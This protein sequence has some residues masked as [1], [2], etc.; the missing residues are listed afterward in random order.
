MK[1]QSTNQTQPFEETKT[2]PQLHIASINN[3]ISYQ[4]YVSSVCGNSVYQLPM[5]SSGHYC[6][7]LN[8][9][10]ALVLVTVSV[11][12]YLLG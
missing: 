9:W 1:L 7:G 6:L 8:F 11:K 5:L 3:V 4:I 2:F 10:H 12:H